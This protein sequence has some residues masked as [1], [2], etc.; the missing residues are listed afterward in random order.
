MSEIELIGRELS[1]RA[2]RLQRTAS[3]YIIE[4]PSA[5]KLPYLDPLTF[6]LILP[7]LPLYLLFVFMQSIGGSRITIT[8]IEKLPGGGYEIIEYTR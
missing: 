8:R 4:Q 5:P 2:E 1:D 7:F 6:I 3:G